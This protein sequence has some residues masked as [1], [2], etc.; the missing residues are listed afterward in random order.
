[1]LCGKEPSVSICDIWQPVQRYLLR[2]LH[3][4]PCALLHLLPGSFQLSLGLLLNLL[5]C[6]RDLDAGVLLQLRGGCLQLLLHFLLL[7]PQPRL[8]LL[9]LDG[10]A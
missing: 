8:K 2:I 3:D 9:H 4:A 7:L 1:M 10:T 5:R 6:R